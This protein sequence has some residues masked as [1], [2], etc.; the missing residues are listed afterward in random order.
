MLHRRRETTWLW[1]I[2]LV[3]ALVRLYH[4]DFQSLWLDEGWQYSIASAQ[5]LR[6]VFDRA[7]EP[8]AAHPPLS[9]LINHLFLQV[10]DSDFFLR[11]PSVLF[12][13]GSLPLCYLLARRFAPPPAAVLAVLVF[14]L[15][16]LHI[17]YSQEARMYAQLIFLSLLSTIFL[18]NALEYAH[19][20]WWVWYTLT[21]TAGMYTHIFMALSIIAQGLWIVL[22]YREHLLS[23]SISMA[24]VSTLFFVPLGPFL[25]EGFKTF[26]Q[27][28]GGAGFSW[29]SLPYTFFA[30]AAGF[31]LGPNTL[32]LHEDRSLS[33]IVQFLPSMLAVGTIFGT[34]F[35][36]GILSSY[37]YVA[38]KYRTLCLLSF[39]IPLL[40][41]LIFSLGP[42]FTFNVRYTVVAFPYFCI[43]IGIA[44]YCL[45]SRKK[46]TFVVSLFA[47]C[48]I[49]FLSLYNYFSNT[50]YSK[51]DIRSAVKLFQEISKDEIILSCNDGYAVDRYLSGKE[52]S[53]HF[54]IQNTLNVVEDIHRL[55][56]V[57]D[58]YSAYLV[59]ARDWNKVIEKEIYTAFSVSEKQEFNGVKILKIY[60]R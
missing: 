29:G 4:L 57:H 12:G 3:G 9:Y 37:K 52:R 50:W 28:S 32:E 11:L 46:L 56:S 51:E 40:G 21:V 43:F 30:Y 44:L 58:I 6:G 31:S 60:Q 55:F 41:T 5:S 19:T 33:F 34:L 14:A 10:Q 18:L 45:Y 16:P 1:L 8:A 47:I 24:A 20:K 42:R 38:I 7:L 59:L 49:L 13:I 25:L 39:C 26:R 23:Y 53:L 17:W 22:Y 48:A 27:P 36:S 35:I 15:S 2:V 54:P